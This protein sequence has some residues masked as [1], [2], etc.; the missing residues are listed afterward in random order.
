VLVADVGSELKEIRRNSEEFNLFPDRPIIRIKNYVEQ[1]IFQK[2][3]NSFRVEAIGKY[4][5]TFSGSPNITIS[6]HFENSIQIHQK[7]FK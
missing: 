7:K 3:Y 2:T 4:F 1:G 6:C 5:T